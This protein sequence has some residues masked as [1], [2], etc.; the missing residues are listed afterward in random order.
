MEMEW[1]E[2]ARQRDQVRRL[3]ASQ[4]QQQHQTSTPL[5]PAEPPGSPTSPVSPSDWQCLVGCDVLWTAHPDPRI[6]QMRLAKELQRLPR[7]ESLNAPNKFREPPQ[8]HRNPWPTEMSQL[9]LRPQ[10][11]VPASKDCPS[12]EPKSPQRLPEFAPPRLIQGNSLTLQQSQPIQVAKIDSPSGGSDTGST[13][14]KEPVKIREDPASP[15][16]RS[17]RHHRYMKSPLA[18]SSSI[19]QAALDPSNDHENSTPC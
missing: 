15:P 7:M 14:C 11:N 8:V 10:S 6:E 3:E 1:R 13:S 19:G 12:W 9:H 5:P 4:Q 17:N 16:A 2:Q 18:E